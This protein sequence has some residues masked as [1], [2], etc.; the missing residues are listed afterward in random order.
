MPLCVRR[1]KSCFPNFSGCVRV[2]ANTFPVLTC[3]VRR[4]EIF[5]YP[6]SY[7]KSQTSD[8]EVFVNMRWYCNHSRSTFVLL[9]HSFYGLPSRR[10]EKTCFLFEIISVVSQIVLKNL[11][12]L[13]NRGVCKEGTCFFM[14]FL[15]SEGMT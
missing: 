12:V 2:C 7:A 4:T 15:T 3:N 11:F 9:F 8:T 1:T 14:S 6:R 10:T 5:S 13:K